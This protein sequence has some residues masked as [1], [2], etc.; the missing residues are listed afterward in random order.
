MYV[1]DPNVWRTFYKKNMLA[2]KF[3][4]AQYQGRQTEGGGGGGG[5]LPVCMP[6]NLIWSPSILNTTEPE[7]KVVI[8][9]QVSPVTA[10]GER[11]KSDLKESI[12]DTDL[13]RSRLYVKCKIIKIR[14]F[15]LG[16]RQNDW[17]HQRSAS[18]HSS[19][20]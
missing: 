5:A 10:V 8:G 19:N 16:N 9:Q 18:E 6:R 4:P 12:E 2:G 11:A 17:H 7:E 3:N 1:S 15:S 13:R 20:R 14:R